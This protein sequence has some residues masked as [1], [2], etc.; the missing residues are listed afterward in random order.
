M[1][2]N[3]VRG[4]RVS[5]FPK[6]GVTKMYGLTLVALRGGGWV[7]Q[8]SRKKRYVTLEWPRTNAVSQTGF[9]GS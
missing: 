4:G 6:K 5:D 3:A 8:I 1:L 2:Y 7:C 9:L